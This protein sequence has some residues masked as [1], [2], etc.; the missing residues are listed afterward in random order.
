MKKTIAILAACCMLA[1]TSASARDYGRH[2]HHRHSGGSSWVVPLVI[3]GTAVVAS[4]YYSQER[5]P[6]AQV[7]YIAPPPPQCRAVP[8]QGYDRYGQY[9]S[10]YVTECYDPQS[11]NWYPMTP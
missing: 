8:I 10:F 5:L 3:V 4:A 6:E 2:H 1:A 9:H 11:G 7:R